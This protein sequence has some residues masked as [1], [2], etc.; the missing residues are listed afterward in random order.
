MYLQS[1]INKKP[2]WFRF[3]P[4][5]SRPVANAMYPYIFLP[6]IVYDN[7]TSDRPN[8]K[9]IALLTHE[10]THYERQQTVGAFLYAL[11]YLLSQR[12]RQREE[13][14]GVTAAISYLKQN[15]ISVDLDNL[16]I[17]DAEYLF[18]WPIS[19]HYNV[20]ELKNLYD[21]V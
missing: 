6:K 20:R 9:Y 3:I 19:K 21:N 14:L 15:N 2:N 8:P 4:V 16:Q 18:L 5:L 1:Y 13:L 17:L 12:F 11:K 10:Q 7:L